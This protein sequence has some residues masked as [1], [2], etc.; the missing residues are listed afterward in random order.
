MKLIDGKLIIPQ[1][2]LRIETMRGHGNGGQHRNKTESAVRITHVSTGLQEYC[3]DQRSQTEN[4]RIALERLTKRLIFII[5]ESRKRRL[6]E[7]FPSN[8][9]II[10]SYNFQRG[11]VK[12]HRTGEVKDL[13][14]VLEGKI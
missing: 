5:R 4:K 12:D 13:N 2:E 7:Q 6:R 14:S 8:P 9:K 10:K 1:D 11:T 3:Q